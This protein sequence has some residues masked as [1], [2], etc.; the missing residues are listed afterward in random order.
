MAV[1][2]G[3]PVPD[4][5]SADRFRQVLL[6]ASSIGYS[7]SASGTYLSTELFPKLG[8]WEQL[9]PKSK[10]ILSER[11]AT[12]VARGDVEIG[13]QQVSEILPIEGVTYVGLIPS[14]YQKVTTF[15]AGVTTRAENDKDAQLLIDYLASPEVAAVIS[16]TGLEPVALER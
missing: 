8:L 12:V 9:E 3:A 6:D 4:I 11:I 7:A 2:A 10:R 5:S 16:G 15:S 14:E 1:R 13:F